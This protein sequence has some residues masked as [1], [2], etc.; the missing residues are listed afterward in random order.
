MVLDPAT[1]TA[2]DGK[3]QLPKH[4]NALARERAGALQPT[5]SIK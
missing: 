4:F 1:D 3:P 5:R 2:Q